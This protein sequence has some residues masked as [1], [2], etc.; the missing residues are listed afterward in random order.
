MSHSSLIKLG[1]HVAA[2]F[3]GRVLTILI[4]HRVLEN[5]DPLFPNEMHARRF[6]ELLERLKRSWRI[7]P[8]GKSVAMLSAGILPARSLAITF[9]DGYADNASIA[10]PLL[11]KHDCPA[12]IFI[13]TGYLNGGRMWNDTVI[14]SVRNSDRKH[15][16]FSWIPGGHLPLGDAPAKRRVID[17]LIASVKHLSPPEREQKCREV[18][19]ACGGALPDDLMLTTE[20][21]LGLRGGCIDFGA[22]TVRHP[23]LASLPDEE[24][25]REIRQGKAEL[26]AI[27]GQTVQIFA[28]PNGKPMVDYLPKHVDMVRAAGFT[29]AVST[30]WGACSST[31][32][33]FQLPR[34]SPWDQDARKFELRLVRNLFAASAKHSAG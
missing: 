13:S 11:R 4:F 10:Y 22:H 17:C 8:L 6:D 3:S 5:P 19:Q 30:H 1:A 7:M 14:E 21:L 26:E 20:Q 9:D 24:A 29:A 34:F 33:R 15:L 28:Y 31:S 23:I 12:T 2:T 16:N 25:E 32:D 27:L 18:A